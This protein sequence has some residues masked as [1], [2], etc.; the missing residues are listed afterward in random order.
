[1]SKS[2]AERIELGEFDD[3]L[4][5]L[6]TAIHHRFVA[7]RREQ[8]ERDKNDPDPRKTTRM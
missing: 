3:E 8:Y 6:S 2:L 7:L 5:A 4:F 1:M